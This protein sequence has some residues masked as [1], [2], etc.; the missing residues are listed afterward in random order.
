MRLSSQYENLT[1]NPKSSSRHGRYIYHWSSTPLLERVSR[2]CRG[3]QS[4]RPLVRKQESQAEAQNLASTL[5][6]RIRTAMFILQSKDTA[7][8]PKDTSQ[9][10]CSPDSISQLAL[11]NKPPS[12]PNSFQATP[13][14]NLNL[15]VR[16]KTLGHIAWE[17]F[18]RGT[19]NSRMP[20]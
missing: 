5:K 17:N 15:S 14:H 8:V 11:A 9:K 3:S 16:R 12:Y 10:A 19:S 2:R 18:N 20:E 6:T 4:E 13:K 7:V 1:N